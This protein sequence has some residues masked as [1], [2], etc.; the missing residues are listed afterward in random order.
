MVIDD[1]YIGRFT[2]TGIGILEA[3]GTSITYN[4][5]S[6]PRIHSDGIIDPLNVRTAFKVGGYSNLITSPTVFDDSSAGMCYSF[7]FN[8]DGA[9]QDRNFIIGGSAEGYIKGQEN[10]LNNFFDCTIVKRE[11]VTPGLYLNDPVQTFKHNVNNILKKYSFVE[12]NSPWVGSGVT[13]ST[14]VSS[15]EFYF[16]KHALVQKISS[17]ASLFYYD[18]PNKNRLAG[19]TVTFT[20]AVKSSVKCTVL[21][22]EGASGFVRGTYHSG[23][24]VIETLS[25]T[26]LIFATGS[27]VR[28]AVLIDSDIPLNT[29][30]SIDWVNLSIGTSSPSFPVAPV[31]GTNDTTSGVAQIATNQLKV[32]VTHGLDRTPESRDFIL[33]PTNNLGN[34]GKWWLSNINSN[35]FDINVDVLPATTVATFA[36]RI[37]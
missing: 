10:I 34:A 22:D 29:V 2:N 37:F 7:D 16:S 32:T 3:T 35:T 33:T 26:K 6:K 27:V 28:L 31:I 19:K 5:I 24:G 23:S 1:V 4:T 14:G 11:N 30:I 17:G 20:A 21:I 18:I 36:Y 13:N 8:H 12:G 15:S 25:V 9:H